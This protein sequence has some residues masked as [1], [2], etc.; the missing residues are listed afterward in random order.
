MGSYCQFW[1]TCFAVWGPGRTS[2]R[3]KNARKTPTSSEKNKERK[4]G[5]SY[6]S[7]D[8]MTLVARS[9][10]KEVKVIT[11]RRRRN[12]KREKLGGGR[13]KKLEGSSRPVNDPA[14]RSKALQGTNT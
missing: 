3:E 10:G 9:A 5:K 12:P 2:G 6:Q 1:S 7:R 13:W 11:K 8:E 4:K 14:P